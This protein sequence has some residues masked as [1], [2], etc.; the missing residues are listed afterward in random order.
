MASKFNLNATFK[1]LTKKLNWVPK[2]WKSPK[3]LRTVFET[4]LRK[5]R[6][7]AKELIDSEI[8]ESDFFHTRT[9]F[10]G[11]FFR[12][13]KIVDKQGDPLSNYTTRDKNDQKF[14]L[15]KKEKSEIFKFRERKKNSAERNFK[16]Q[17]N[18]FSPK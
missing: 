13:A 8:A 11:F 14:L 10:L 9:C 6:G 1:K 12:N 3:I 5:S 2:T 16:F 15:E 18:F 17:R 4:D 7:A